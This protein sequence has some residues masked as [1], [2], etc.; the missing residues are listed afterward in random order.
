MKIFKQLGF[1]SRRTILPLVCK[2]WLE[3]TRTSAALWAEVTVSSAEEQLA[4]TILQRSGQTGGL[5]LRPDKFLSIGRSPVFRWFQTHAVAATSLVL[6][7][8]GTSL[9]PAEIRIQFAPGATPTNTILIAQRTSLEHL[10]VRYVEHI[11]TEPYL[12][13]LGWLTKLK[14]LSLGVYGGVQFSAEDLSSLACLSNLEVFKMLGSTQRAVTAPFPDAFF[15]LPNLK[16]LHLY[17]IGADGFADR[18]GR[19]TGLTTLVA[20]LCRAGVM[21]VAVQAATLSSLIT[22]D[23][24]Q[25]P[26]LGGLPD[27]SALGALRTLRC[28]GCSIASLPVERLRE[29]PAVEEI[30]FSGAP[31]MVIPENVCEL[32]GLSQ[33]RFL[34][35]RGCKPTGDGFGGMLQ[36]LNSVRDRSPDLTVLVESKN[37]PSTSKNSP[38]KHVFV[39]HV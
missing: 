28:R 22:L 19:L 8:V 3:L 5:K 6:G 2:Q 10:C 13:H 29:L 23:L 11:R 33:L 4:F 38:N 24:S 27:L 21:K 7:N 32:A 1:A 31:K 30:D 35:V 16:H 37:L 39:I 15:S 17:N 36:F 12:S 26:N 18:L 34:S 9:T 25:N 20:Q 14:S